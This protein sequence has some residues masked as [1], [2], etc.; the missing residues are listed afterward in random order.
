ML[1]E[2]NAQKAQSTILVPEKKTVCSRH[3]IQWKLANFWESSSPS[4]PQKWA[5]PKHTGAIPVIA[6]PGF[7]S[8]SAQSNHSLCCLYEALI[9]PTI[10]TLKAP[11]NICWY[12]FSGQRKLA[13]F[14]PNEAHIQFDLG[15][16]KT[17]KDTCNPSTCNLM[18]VL[19]SHVTYFFE[20]WH[21]KRSLNAFGNCKDLGQTMD[22]MS[23]ATA[24]NVCKYNKQV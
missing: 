1:K 11:I 7:I 20:L 6:L 2:M 3:V 10:S 15:H 13:T 17:Y 8:A 24:I 23:L 16:E 18:R 14:P 22:L 5:R 19:D 9:E 12:M 21:A 4:C